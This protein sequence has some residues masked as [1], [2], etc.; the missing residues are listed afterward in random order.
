MITARPGANATSIPI[1]TEVLELPQQ[2]ATPVPVVPQ[3][4][5]PQHL[6]PEPVIPPAP[7]P[8]VM[9]T[10]AAGG[11]A[12]FST[13]LVDAAGLSE[14][15]VQESP[16]GEP[17]APVALA[18]AAPEPAVQTAA[19]PPVDNAIP[20]AI[21]ADIAPPTSP[22]RVLEP[23]ASKPSSVS[24]IHMATPRAVSP[25]SIVPPTPVAPALDL[26]ALAERLHA[27]VLADLQERI[28]PVLHARVMQRLEPVLRTALADISLA[29][30]EEI[31]GLV[32]EAVQKALIK[33]VTTQD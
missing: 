26:D 23:A 25:L 12:T 11:P 15:A 31:A 28:E 21:P 3:E 1:L 4:L 17:A 33:H 29:L 6:I 30:Q 10:R 8:L 32:D 2:L 22:P 5:V 19:A 20:T 16:A 24:A 9:R 27:N 14:H 18:N 7:E 13:R